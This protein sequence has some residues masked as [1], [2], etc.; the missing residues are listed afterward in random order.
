MKIKILITLLFVSIPCFAQD[1]YGKATYKTHRKS[2]IQL[3]ST[4]IAANPGIAEQLK[5]RMQKMSQKTFILDFTKSESVYKEDRQLDAPSR[6]QASGGLMV[7]TVGGGG[8]NDIMYKNVKEDRM[9]NKVDLMG[10][11]FLIKDKLVNYDWKLT[12]ETKNIGKYTCYKA[13]YE[14]E[15]ENI[16]VS[17]VNDDAKQK[18]E[19]VKRTVTAWY[20]PEIPVSNGPQNYWGL[21]G[22]I[23]EIN[24]GRLTIVCTEI[25]INPAEKIEIKEPKKGKVVNREKYRKIS[26]EKTEEM[27]ERFKSRGRNG[28]THIRI[29]G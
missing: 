8:G 3:D 2:N 29:G 15:V 27:M 14:T 25:V 6:P 24:D 18:T 10:K 9:A 22:L 20:S 17:S 11:I 7:M 19:T 16:T 13:I 4:T 21:P 1:F 28:G 26:R 12:G 23:L 5:A